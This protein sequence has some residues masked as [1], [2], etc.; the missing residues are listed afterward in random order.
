[1]AAKTHG[2]A[3]VYGITETAFTNA[4]LLSVT[5]NRADKNVDYTPN[6]SGQN[7]HIR[8]DDERTD[9]TFTFQIAAAYVEPEIANTITIAGS[10]EETRYNGVYMVKSVGRPKVA[11]GFTVVSIVLEKDEYMTYAAN[12]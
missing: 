3:W 7:A 2:T 6:Q 1:M 11:K 10:T 4:T 5:Y 8:S 12:A 9:A